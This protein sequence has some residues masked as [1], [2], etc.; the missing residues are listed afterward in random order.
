MTCCIPAPDGHEA[1]RGLMITRCCCTRALVREE[2]DARVFC[3]RQITRLRPRRARRARK[4][5]LHPS[6]FLSIFPLPLLPV[7]SLHLAPP[8]THAFPPLT[9]HSYRRVL[10]RV[11]R[12]EL[13]G[14]RSWDWQSRYKATWK[15]S[16]LSRQGYQKSD[17]PVVDLTSNEQT[18]HSRNL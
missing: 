16:L 10:V 18:S 7:L 9:L 8:P 13:K 1:L 4:L 15:T 5:S 6:F 3:F 12:E 11:C 14:M 17:P 2:C